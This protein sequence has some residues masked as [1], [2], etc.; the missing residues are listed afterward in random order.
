MQENFLKTVVILNKE[1]LKLNKNLLI[2][3]AFSTIV[4][5]S[6][7]QLLADQEDYLNTTYTV[8]A[9]YSVF[10]SAF[11]ILF[12]IDFKQRYKLSSGQTNY[13]LLKKELIQ[14]ITSLGIGEIVYLA[15]RWTAQYYF[16]NLNFE[17]YLASLSAEAISIV[18]YL[19]VVSISGKIVGLFK[20]DNK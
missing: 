6:V 9:G 19:F 15:V 10:F 11:I 2:S 7:A 5:T 18:C 8:I 20:D 17:P 3:L 16:L 4:S 12:Y 1:Y 14:L 13:G